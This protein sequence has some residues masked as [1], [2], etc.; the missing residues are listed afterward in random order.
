MAKFKMDSP[1]LQIGIDIQFA[2]SKG[3]EPEL[4]LMETLRFEFGAKT[5]YDEENGIIRYQLPNL[6]PVFYSRIYGDETTVFIVM[7]SA[8][9]LTSHRT[10]SIPQ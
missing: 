10:P 6:E 7:G 9:L 3:V 2:K 1:D 5:Y 4:L 8:S